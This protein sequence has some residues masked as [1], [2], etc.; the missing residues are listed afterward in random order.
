L[1]KITY[2]EYMS[3]S[4]C[5]AMVL[6]AFVK[7][8]TSVYFY[9]ENDTMDIP[10]RSIPGWVH[11]NRQFRNEALDQFYRKTELYAGEFSTWTGGR[12][13]S[14][15]FSIKRVRRLTITGIHAIPHPRLWVAYPW[16]SLS[17]ER[18]QVIE[19]M[20]SFDIC[21]PD[22]LTIPLGQLAC[23]ANDVRH[24]TLVVSWDTRSW[25]VGWEMTRGYSD[26]ESTFHRILP[27]NLSALEII[28]TSEYKLELVWKELT[29][30]L[31]HFMD[32]DSFFRAQTYFATEC[33]KVATRHLREPEKIRSE[34]C[35]GSA[36]VRPRGHN[37]REQIYF[38]YHAVTS[39]WRSP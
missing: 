5:T 23:I 14:A 24:V 33:D 25:M 9:D 39:G 37:R 18:K 30:A 3:T 17:A 31:S 15:F 27:K 4:T 12:L 1:R 13:I 34:A 8:R 36:V 35:I 7:T 32:Q 16:G 2:L 11:S 26:V 20:G 19:Q 28:S 29:T 6:P 22:Q 10:S 21:L 38:Q